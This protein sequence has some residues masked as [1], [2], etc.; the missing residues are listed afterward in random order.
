M[1]VIFSNVLAN[2]FLTKEG[3]PERDVMLPVMGRP[4]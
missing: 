3:F 4:K 1:L 2:S